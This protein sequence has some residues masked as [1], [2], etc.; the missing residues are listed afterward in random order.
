MGSGQGVLRRGGR[1]KNYFDVRGFLLDKFMRMQKPR[2]F[3]IGYTGMRLRMKTPSEVRRSL[4]YV[5][6][7]VLAGELDP[8]SANAIVCAG[9]AILASL[10]IDEQQKEMDAL[11]DRIDGMQE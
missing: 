8:R 2:A 1:V 5:A 10:R 6:N 4:T 9:N 7:K 11:E 3:Q